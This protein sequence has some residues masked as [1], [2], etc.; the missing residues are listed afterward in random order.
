ML[1][2]CPVWVESGHWLGHALAMASNRALRVS[3]ASFIASFACFATFDVTS[4]RG[5]DFPI[6]PL[7]APGQ[8]NRM[9]IYASVAGNHALW[10]DLSSH[11]PELT[12]PQ[13]PCIIAIDRLT[14]SGPRRLARSVLHVAATY[15]WGHLVS[16][17]SDSF[18]L[19][20][21]ESD[22]VVRDEGCP[23]DYSFQGGAMYVFHYSPVI[24]SFRFLL[25][26]LAYAFSAVAFGALA[27]GSI[28][29]RRG[30]KGNG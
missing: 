25:K 6:R 23:S 18:Q 22:I 14:K 28:T 2:E 24:L 17:S 7:P 11:D 29:A 27:Y 4:V 8:D 9:R 19:P 1:A 13:I 26:W 3:L 5:S 16:Y 21:G 15:S 10:V 30:A 20:R 12:A